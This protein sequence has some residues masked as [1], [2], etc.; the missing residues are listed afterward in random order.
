MP[1]DTLTDEELSGL[2]NAILVE[3]ER[4]VSLFQIP[5]QI[6]ELSARYQAGGGNVEA[7]REALN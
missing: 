2:L 7:L 6:Q 1:L 4:R 3:Q 5:S